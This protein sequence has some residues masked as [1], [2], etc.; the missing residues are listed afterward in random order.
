MLME[1]YTKSTTLKKELLLS[2]I[3]P[4]HIHAHFVSKCL[5]QATPAFVYAVMRSRNIYQ[6][7]FSVLVSIPATGV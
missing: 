2:F 7:I 5:Q 4:S 6:L 3:Q 1:V